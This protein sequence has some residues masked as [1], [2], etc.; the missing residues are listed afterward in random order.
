MKKASKHAAY[1]E[2]KQQLDLEDVPNRIF[3]SKSMKNQLKRYV[4]HKKYNS[5]LWGQPFVIDMDFEHHMDERHLK[6]MVE[7]VCLLSS[8]NGLLRDPF[9]LHFCNVRP[10][11]KQYSFM[12]KYFV[13]PFA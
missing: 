10:G 7:Q 8:L 11:G 5:V 9:H 1:I 4:M 13:A 12:E 3:D 6:N 2:R